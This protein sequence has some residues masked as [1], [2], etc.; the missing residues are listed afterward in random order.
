MLFILC[1]ALALADPPF[2]CSY[3]MPSECQVCNVN[4]FQPP[5]MHLSTESCLLLTWGRAQGKPVA[6]IFKEKWCLCHSWVYRRFPHQWDGGRKFLQVW[7]SSGGYCPGGDGV[8][9]SFASQPGLCSC[10]ALKVLLSWGD[11]NK[12]RTT[13]EGDV[14]LSHL[15]LCYEL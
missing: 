12:E 1:L 4:S 13:R 5:V 2:P 3:R 15:I 8:T 14:F 10:S 7:W 11:W 9:H 6:H